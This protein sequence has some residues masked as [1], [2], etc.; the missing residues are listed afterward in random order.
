VT[1]PGGS[2]ASFAQR[3]LPVS[4]SY[5]SNACVSLV[6]SAGSQ[7]LSI[8]TLISLIARKPFTC[9]SMSFFFQDCPLLFRFD[10]LAIQTFSFLGQRFSQRLP[11]FFLWCN[12]RSLF[13]EG[14]I[15]FKNF[16]TQDRL[17]FSCL[18]F[19]CKQGEFWWR[20]INQG[21]GR[22]NIRLC[23]AACQIINITIIA[24]LVDF[25]QS[26]FARCNKRV[27]RNRVRNL[28]SEA[29]NTV[30]AVTTS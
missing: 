10:S 26:W 20:G 19:I 30:A 29:F 9:R 28:S 13:L 15:R 5:C 24:A 3:G 4:P 7:R 16:I 6:T 8:S 27:A 14:N 12:F 18:L 2:S 22:R 23:A 21:E 25:I 1:E 17:A 11:L